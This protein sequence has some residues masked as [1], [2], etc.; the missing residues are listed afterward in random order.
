MSTLSR[1]VPT[2]PSNRW[3]LLP[4]MA[5]LMTVACENPEVGDPVMRISGVVR[6]SVTSLPIDSAQACVMEVTTIINC[7]YSDG[8]GRYQYL[9]L[10]TGDFTVRCERQ[11]YTPKSLTIRATPMHLRLDGVD[12]EMVAVR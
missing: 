9:G 2:S 1:P 10:G 5:V 6:D 4:L 12:F 7:S 3:C 11:G 8:L